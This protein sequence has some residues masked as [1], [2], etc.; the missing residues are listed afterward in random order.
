MQKALK[1]V[2]LAAEE[3]GL[4]RPHGGTALGG[5][6]L[7]EIGFEALVLDGMADGTHIGNVDIHVAGE[8]GGVEHRRRA[9]LADARGDP[10]ARVERREE[11]PDAV[12]VMGRIF[13]REVFPVERIGRRAV[14]IAVLDKDD[15][16]IEEF[17]QLVAVTFGKGK[18]GVIA[19]RDEHRGAIPADMHHHHPLKERSLRGVAPVERLLD[20]D[21]VFSGEFARGERLRLRNAFESG[22]A[23][24]D[25]AAVG[26]E[27]GDGDGQQKQ[28]NQGKSFQHR[29]SDRCFNGQRYAFFDAPQYNS[30]VRRGSLA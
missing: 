10:L 26:S 27:N 1:A 22:N 19:L 14:E 24:L 7:C 30:G 25:L 13:G 12:Q 18:V 3:F 21:L 16:R 29:D 20:H 9:T 23:P 15:I 8:E 11:R 5:S 17:R 4:Q 6:H 2:G 28:T